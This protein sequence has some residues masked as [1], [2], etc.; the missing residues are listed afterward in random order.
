MIEITQSDLKYIPGKFRVKNR[1][2]FEWLRDVDPFWGVLPSH[3]K[4]GKKRRAG[5]ANTNRGPFCD[6]IDQGPQVSQIQYDVRSIY[7]LLLNFSLRQT[8][9]IFNS[10][11]QVWEEGWRNAL[12]RRWPSWQRGIFHQPYDLY[13]REVWYEDCQGR[14]FRSCW[15]CDQ[16][17]RWKR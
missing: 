11:H 2:V 6:N 5:D 1:Y 4:A 7:L 16:V 14:D 12:P 8:E 13:R 9:S 17:W 3:R 15:R 10:V